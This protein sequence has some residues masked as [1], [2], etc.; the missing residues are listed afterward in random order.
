MTGNNSK[1]STYTVKS[2]GQKWIWFR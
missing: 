1:H 2:P